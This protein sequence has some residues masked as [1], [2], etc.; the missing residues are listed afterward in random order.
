MSDKPGI[1]DP[2]R[3]D[4][5]IHVPPAAPVSKRPSRINLGDD[6]DADLAPTKM[7]ALDSKHGLIEAYG[8]N[9]LQMG[10][11]LHHVVQCLF[12]LSRQFTSALFKEAAITFCIEDKRSAGWDEAPSSKWQTEV[13]YEPKCELRFK[14]QTL[15]GGMLRLIRALRDLQRRPGGAAILK[16][17]GV[18][19]IQ[20]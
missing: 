13:G 14:R 19:I 17:W 9:V 7:G 1:V 11:V 2:W 10:D 12:D 8:K 15:D 3:V 6:L 16:K 20:R 18:R 5:P 4:E